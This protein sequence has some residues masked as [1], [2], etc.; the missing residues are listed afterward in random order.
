MRFIVYVGLFFLGTLLGYAQEKQPVFSPP[1]DFPLTL[2]GNFGELRSNHFHGGLDFKT[3]GVSGKAVR[4]LADGFIARIRV[5]NGSGLVLE[6]DYDNGYYTINR[7][8]SR[9][10]P[11]IAERVADKQYAEESYEVEIVPEPG[12]Y[13]VHAGDVIG[14]SGNTGYSFGPHLHLDVLEKETGFYVDP[15]PLFG[16]VIRDHTSPRAQGFLI[17]PKLGKGVVDGQA[18]PLSV[19]VASGRRVR[20]WG[21]IGVAV[22]AYDYMDGTSNK[23]GVK[24][25]SLK[26]DGQ[27][28]FRSVVDRF[29]YAENP[30]INSWT[31]KN[32]MKSFVEPG[33]RLGMLQTFNDDCGWLTV[34]EERVYCLDYT[35][36]DASGNQCNYRLE[37]QGVRQEIPEVDRL[38]PCFWSWNRTNVLREPGMQ[39]IVPKGL[40][41]DDVL[42][43]TEVNMDTAS[44]AY[45]YQLHDRPV[46]FHK[47]EAELSIGLL[48]KPV[49]DST[50]YFVARVTPSGL[51]GVGGRYDNGY[52]H[53]R[54][55]QLGTYTVSV[56]T[57]P[58]VVRAVN[59]GSWARKK[60]MTFSISD[61]LTGISSYRGTVD[62]KFVVFG[63]PNLTKS[64]YVCPLDVKRIPRTGKRRKV[65]MEAFDG[66]GNRSVAEA[67]FIW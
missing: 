32:Y 9:F 29:A 5:T 33:N 8:L 55:R 24:T 58:P 59:P 66:C 61:R 19:S 15:M 16:G 51:Y 52:M 44:I 22:K 21:K 38:S 18:D 39:L 65:V 1:F 13:P 3:G 67:S 50:K 4:A 34:D 63:R 48:R 42:L 64:F 43:R 2:S 25:V 17:Y 57:V 53:V 28:I 31:E 7:H 47:P 14:W 49:A 11:E 36:Q 20:V 54:I 45:T 40:L 37:L 6:V 35:L 27:E 10:L 62:G 26:V 23:Y 12:E 56:D 41:Y 60:E 30:Y 46:V